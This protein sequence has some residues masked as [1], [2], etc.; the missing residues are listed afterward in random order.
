MLDISAFLLP[1]DNVVNF[2][3]RPG[4]PGGGLLELYIGA[5]NNVAGTLELA[6]PSIT[7]SRRASDDPAGTAQQFTLSVP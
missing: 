5:G 6:P 4:E 1:G 3:A 7:F 2:N